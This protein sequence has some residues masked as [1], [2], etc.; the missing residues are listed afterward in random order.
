MVP[1]GL[2]FYADDQQEEVM[3]HDTSDDNPIRSEGCVGQVSVLLNRVVGIQL[4]RHRH[5]LYPSGE[6]QR[7]IDK[8]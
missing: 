6:K 5:K 4:E 8:E 1:T 2:G 7:W 3:S